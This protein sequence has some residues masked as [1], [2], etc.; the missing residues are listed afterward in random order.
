MHAKTPKRVKVIC[1]EF[2]WF[3]CTQNLFVKKKKKKGWLE[4]VM[5]TSIYYTTD[6]YPY[7]HAYRKFIC[8]HL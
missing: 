8:D 6:T 5:V 4:I 3:L 1:F 2:W 7:Q